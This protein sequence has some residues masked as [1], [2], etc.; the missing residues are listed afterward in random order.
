MKSN[1]ISNQ[2]LYEQGK[3]TEATVRAVGKA[4]SAQ[5]AES[6]KAILAGQDDIKAKQDELSKKM[7]AAREERNQSFKRLENANAHGVARLEAK[8][9]ELGDKFVESFFGAGHWALAIIASIIS[10]IVAFIATQ[11]AIAE[12]ASA[13]VWQVVSYDTY[14]NVIKVTEH[15]SRVHQWLVI[16]LI[17][18]LVF[19]FI[20]TIY[21][22]M[23]L[24][25]RASKNEEDTES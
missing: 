23:K 12:K 10:M 16:G 14:G 21:A 13:Y 24:T 22:I 5:R 18:I 4:S 15:I 1:S 25:R 17:G 6:T 20:M 2:T 8:I 19:S 7:D 3:K 9:N 11:D